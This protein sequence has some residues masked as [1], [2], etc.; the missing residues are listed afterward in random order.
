MIIGFTKTD[1]VSFTVE[2]GVKFILLGNL[3]SVFSSV[4]CLVFIVETYV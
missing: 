3:K 1:L 4:Y 2:V